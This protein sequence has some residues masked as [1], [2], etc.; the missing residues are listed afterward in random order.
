VKNLPDMKEDIEQMDQQNKFNQEYEQ[1]FEIRGAM[2]DE[3]DE[4]EEKDN[5]MFEIRGAI[6]D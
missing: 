3:D 1:L 6:K 4:E 5:Q 2:K